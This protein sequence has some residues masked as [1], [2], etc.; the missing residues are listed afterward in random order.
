MNV[1]V[2]FRHTQMLKKCKS[3]PLY[4]TITSPFR[5]KQS[6]TEM[7]GE[8][9]SMTAPSPH[10][11]EYS[12]LYKKLGPKNRNKDLRQVQQSHLNEYLEN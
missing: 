5:R 10:D 7:K 2:L 6:Q 9:R 11:G 12:K 3:S 1:P 4:I 8:M